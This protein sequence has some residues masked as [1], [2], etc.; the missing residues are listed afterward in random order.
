MSPSLRK[1]D[2]TPRGRRSSS[3]PFPATIR[4]LLVPLDGS[5]FAEQ[6]LP[7]AAEIARESGARLRLALVHQVPSP[8][9]LDEIS[10]RLYTK[11]ELALRKSEREY[12]RTTAERLRVQH[13]V[14]AARVML[15]GAPAPAPA[16]AE[17]VRD[18]G[19]DLVVMTTHGLGGIRRAWLGS[20]A[21]RL[22]RSL[23]VPM[24]LIR[25]REEADATGEAPQVREILVALDGSRR[26]EAVLAPVAALA[27]VW[28]ARLVLVQVV[29]PFVLTPDA[30]TVFPLGSDER[31]SRLAR[32][33]AQDYLDG[34]VGQLREGG[35]DASSAAVLGTSAFD[36]IQDIARAPGTGLIAL[37]THG[38]G[39][40]RRLVLGSVAD[41]LVRGGEH[42]VLVT[43]PRSR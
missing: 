14:Q 4:S 33:E 32:Q 6:A 28:G 36:A 34:I 35:V 30:P 26:A 7:W 21:D 5:P 2:R 1:A 40:V 10:R 43:R 9:P 41:K 29:H 15:Q 13:E 39:G 22:V 19:V 25:P 12:L 37:A 8:P 23:E 16:L 24:L 42:P 17:Y 20:V 27:G 11:I 18:V 31:L 3:A 38:R